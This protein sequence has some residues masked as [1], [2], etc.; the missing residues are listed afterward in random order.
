MANRDETTLKLLD[1]PEN[2]AMMAQVAVVRPQ[3]KQ[4]VFV[5]LDVDI[6]ATLVIRWLL[7]RWR[8]T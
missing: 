1:G 7:D 2:V 4:R 8:S 6:L 3:Q 5:S